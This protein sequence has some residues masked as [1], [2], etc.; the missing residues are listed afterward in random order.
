MNQD[1][2]I[3]LLVSECSALK[4]QRN[5]AL[6]QVAALSAALSLADGTI[7]ALQGQITE[8]ETK[9][10]PDH[11]AMEQPQQPELQ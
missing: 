10:A 2:R 3:R 9:I 4:A 7:K 11:E 1:H 5:Q 6:D 8:R